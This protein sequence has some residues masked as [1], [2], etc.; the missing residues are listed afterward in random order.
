MHKQ[1]TIL[2]FRPC[3]G[4]LETIGFAGLMT[5]VAI[6]CGQQSA[7]GASLTNWEFDPATNQLE[8]T[9]DEGTMPR[10]FLL[11]Q[12]PRIVIDLPN[13]K[14]GRVQ[15]QKTYSTSVL[16]IRVA[17]LP[18]GVTRIVLDLSPQVVLSPEQVQL[19]LPPASKGNR[20]VLR[21]L[22][23]RTSTASVLLA[24]KPP[25]TLP[26]ATFMT[27]QTS[28]VKVPPLNFTE[29][30]TS[31]EQV[32]A[33]LPPA[34]FRTNKLPTV[35]V[36]TL[37]ATRKAPAPA[38][39]SVIEFGQPLPYSA[40]TLPTTPPLKRGADLLR[41]TPATPRN[42]GT[43]SML[44]PVNQAS[45]TANRRVVVRS[46][47]RL[48]N[49]NSPRLTRRGDRSAL[50]P[51]GILPTGTLLNLSYPGENNLSLR[52][53]TRRQEV[54]LLQQEI[55]DRT[56]RIIVPFGTPI[57]GRFETG[58]SGSRFITQTMILGRLNLPLIAQSS[59]MART[60]ATYRNTRQPTTI[61]PGQILQVQLIKDWRYTRN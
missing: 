33:M 11:S 47:D 17:Q 25:T 14:L 57:I 24:R 1:K 49:N 58:N 18:R 38:T 54:L 26:P 16:Q 13:T 43:R 61:K 34:S 60:N 50:L 42:M 7:Q 10:Y 20:W 29:S 39:T 35:G 6:C 59:I 28:V 41:G 12:P 55:R 53:G 30:L 44:E 22:I 4:L 21:P 31:S 37:Q 46:G 51:N 45:P 8:I 27:S 48:L 5:A 9:L 23:G 36:P 19:I 32:S 2:G 40:A 56:G 15:T 3:I 52:N